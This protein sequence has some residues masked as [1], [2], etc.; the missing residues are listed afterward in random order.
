MWLATRFIK[1]NNKPI[2]S[3]SEEMESLEAQLTTQSDRPRDINET[4]ERIN[5]LAREMRENKR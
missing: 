3:Y 4:K 5:E 2:I 1:K